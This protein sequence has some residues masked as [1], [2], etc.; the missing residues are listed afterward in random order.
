[1]QPL[2]LSSEWHTFDPLQYYWM[3]DPRE[4]S[5]LGSWC[6]QYASTAL[7]ISKNALTNWSAQN[8]VGQG[9]VLYKSI[10]QYKAD[11]EAYANQLIQQYKGYASPP[12]YKSAFDP[13]LAYDGSKL[14]SAVECFDALFNDVDSALL[15]GLLK[16][17][18]ATPFYRGEGRYEILC[19]NHRVVTVV[20]SRRGGSGVTFNGTDT[21]IEVNAPLPFTTQVTLEMWA[22]GIPKE[23][24]L[25]FVT[26]DSHRR[27]LSAHVPYID[28]TVY[29]DSGAD[30]NNNYNRITRAM[31]PVDDQN[32]WNHWAFVRNSVSGRMAIYKNGALWCE[33]PSGMMQ[34]LATCNRLVLG[35]DGDGL[36]YYSGAMTE[37]RLWSVER[38]AAQIHDN[39]NRSIGQ[40]T[41]L[42]AS[43]ALDSYQPDQ[44]IVDR[45][46]GGRHGIL[47][48]SA[49][50]VVG[51]SAL[52]R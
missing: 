22:R 39:M 16:L 40:D 38:T 18:V 50:T 4:L 25:F 26:D 3:L 19:T 46:G 47:H 24:F 51:P 28:G 29:F 33:Q 7:S 44:A 11:Y 9:N 15:P 49:V 32:T 45:S 52:V 34:P 8:Q 41:G 20:V 36:W 48:G 5:N 37:V 12:V 43:Y 42:I 1:M 30:G 6:I 10:A 14:F 23:A 35:A 31:T 21:Y 2:S 17:F 27:Q 13:L